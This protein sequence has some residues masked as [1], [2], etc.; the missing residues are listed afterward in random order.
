[1]KLKI[2]ARVEADVEEAFNYYHA[3]R[4]ELGY[5]FL[6]EFRHAVELIIQFPRAWALIDKDTRRCRLK[7]FLYGIIYEID[8]TNSVMTITTLIHLHRN[9]GIWPRR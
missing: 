8:E 9:P 6:D 2:L 4:P 1:M 5:E 3:I 7:R